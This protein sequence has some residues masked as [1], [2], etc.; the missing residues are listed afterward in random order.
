MVPISA[1]VMRLS[2]FLGRLSPAA[3]VVTGL[4]M[5]LAPSRDAA[6]VLLPGGG[7]KRSDCLAVLD[8]DSPFPGEPGRQGPCVDADPSCDHDGLCDGTCRF[9]VRICINDEGV[10]QCRPPAALRSVRVRGDL[11]PVP[12]S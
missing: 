8:V 1:P 10:G 9:A 12:A 11:V 2:G 7:S 6:G 3:A 4:L 5:T